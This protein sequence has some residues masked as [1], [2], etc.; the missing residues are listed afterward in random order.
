MKN[1]EQK[2]LVVDD[3]KLSAS[4][5]C[6]Q[7]KKAGFEVFMVY[8]G[9][10]AIHFVQKNKVDLVL[11]DIMMPGI[12]GIGVLKFIRCHFS[13]AQLPV[14]MVTALDD[15]EI[16][17][18]ALKEGANDYIIKPINFKV[19]L[20]RLKAHLHLKVNRSISLKE[21]EL[22]AFR[23]LIVTYNHEINGPLSS[24]YQER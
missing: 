3:S 15:E 19:S 9:E 22:K 4:T 7:L 16:I 14:L 12:S 17:V 5:L 1:Q 2:I 18:E 13:P 11:L 8:S 21:S 23:S 6:S 20:G 24:C 10:E